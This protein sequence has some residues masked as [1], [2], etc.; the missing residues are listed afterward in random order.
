MNAVWRFAWMLL[1]PLAA[2]ASRA[3][4]LKPLIGQPEEAVIRALGVPN[5]T[6]DVNGH[7]FLTYE[8]ITTANFPAGPIGPVVGPYGW[9]GWGYWD[10]V[11]TVVYPCRTT[12][13]L[14]K[15]RVI[16]FHLQGDGC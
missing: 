14:E 11:D 6:A 5:R 12:F 13:E 2:C 15:G 9:S 1:V 4:A 16:G 7:R 8:T 10:G 3:D